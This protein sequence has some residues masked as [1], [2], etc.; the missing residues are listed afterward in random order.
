[1]PNHMTDAAH[2]ARTADIARGLPEDAQSNE[3]NLLRQATSQGVSANPNFRAEVWARINA[4]VQAP[5]TWG[6]WLRG[7][8]MGVGLIAAACVLL[9]GAG[10]SWLALEQSR[11]QQQLERYVASIDAHLRLATMP[12]S[13]SEHRQ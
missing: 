3:R 11:S 13:P 10:G 8:A 4:G 1:M 2:A 5:A 9:A 6:Q 12:E 7:H